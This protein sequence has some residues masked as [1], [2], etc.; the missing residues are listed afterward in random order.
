[1]T[2]SFFCLL[3]KL[4]L[5]NYITVGQIRRNLEPLANEALIDYIQIFVF[6]WCFYVVLPVGLTYSRTPQYSNDHYTAH[7]M[8]LL[9]NLT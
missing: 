2:L 8:S 6:L 7:N 9:Q 1:M 3:L 4:L 5:Q